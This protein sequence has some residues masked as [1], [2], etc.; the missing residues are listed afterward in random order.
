MLATELGKTCI[1]YVK[2]Y[3]TNVKLLQLLFSLLDYMIFS[4]VKFFKDSD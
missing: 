4:A 1:A 3:V 2:A